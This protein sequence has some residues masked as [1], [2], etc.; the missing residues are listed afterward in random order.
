MHQEFQLFSRM[1]SRIYSPCNLYSIHVDQNSGNLLWQDVVDL[2]VNYSNVFV[3]KDR[4]HVQWADVSVVEAELRTIR[5]LVDRRKKWDTFIFLSGVHYPLK[6][7]EEMALVLRY[8]PSKNYFYG[9]YMTSRDVWRIRTDDLEEKMDK[10][11]LV[12]TS[13]WCILGYEA[14]VFL[15]ADP[16]AQEIFEWGRHSVTTD[17]WL[18]ATMVRTSPVHAK[19]FIIVDSDE[20]EFAH[21]VLWEN[22]DGTHP[23]TLQEKDIPRVVNATNN[24]NSLFVRKIDATSIPSLDKLDKILKLV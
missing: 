19:S 18:I 13:Q 2:T 24:Y 1:F 16:L 17:E 23:G 21:I 20:V 9:H 6:T 22:G 7:Q 14:S 12:T 10:Y 5:E 3:I 4:V 15:V 8:R 11:V